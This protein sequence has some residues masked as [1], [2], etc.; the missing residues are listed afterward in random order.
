LWIPCLR[1]WLGTRFMPM[2]SFR[3]VR[4]MS[5]SHSARALIFSPDGNP[6]PGQ[7]RLPSRRVKTAPRKQTC[8]Q[9]VQAQ[10]ASEDEGDDAGTTS[11][12]ATNKKKP[13]GPAQATKALPAQSVT[14]RQPDGQ[15]SSWDNRVLSEAHAARKDSQFRKREP[16]QQ[17][18]VA[19]AQAL[20]EHFGTAKMNKAVI[21][22][23]GQEA[24]LPCSATS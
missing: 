5:L 14:H 12:Q 13:V 6:K 10:R 24:M 21:R 17:N 3:W 9:H 1:L 7:R 20:F 8:T 15:H 19:P 16:R 11:P 22:L 23:E 18:S 4:A 2:L